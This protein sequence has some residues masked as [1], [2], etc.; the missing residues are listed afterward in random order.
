MDKMRA[1]ELILMAKAEKG[2]TFSQIAEAVDR[3]PV[4]TTSA[5]LG[6]QQMSVCEADAVTG[7]LGLDPEVARALQRPAPRGSVDARAAS[8]TRW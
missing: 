7:L 4:W 6:Q 2:L 1:M 3:H 8:F 5:L